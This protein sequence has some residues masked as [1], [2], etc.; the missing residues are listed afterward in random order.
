[1][2][3][4]AVLAHGHHAI[5]EPYAGGLEMHTGM[6]CQQ[7]AALGHEIV[8]FAKGGSTS[9]GYEV[10]VI[11]PAD[12]QFMAYPKGSWE[13]RRQNSRKRHVYLDAIT[14]IE[15]DGFDYI[16]NNSLN[17]G[18][19]M[20]RTAVP[21]LTIF[22]TPV[23]EEL[24][25]APKHAISLSNRRFLTVSHVNAADWRPLVPQVE[26]VH[27]GVDL[28][29]WHPSAAPTDELR[30]SARITEEKGL[31]L[32]IEAARLTGRR[33]RI[34]GPISDPRYFAEQIQPHL[35]DQ[36][37]YVGH[38]SHQDLPTFLSEGAVALA[39]PMWEEPFGLSVVE[40]L[41]CGTPVAALPRGAMR[42]IVQP[43]V[44]SV[45]TE[46]TAAA[47]AVAIEE[48]AGKERLACQAYVAANFSMRSMV[49]A[50]LSTLRSMDAVD[51]DL[52]VESNVV[53]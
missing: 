2:A 53:A 4:I 9:N 28:S 49:R 22:H 20:S 35:S 8:L 31:H 39:T 10:E 14:K 48:A 7:L 25:E 37:E 30:W 45:A 26:V 3:R 52:N 13:A 34:A 32:A 29:V 38:L 27:N 43:D 42:E 19:L 46:S 1:M 40:A 24:E 33:L 44:G 36:I 15:R 17:A 16:I 11:H 23:I 18:P 41:A 12:Q 5:C 47:L 21:M 51:V 50:Y 6:L